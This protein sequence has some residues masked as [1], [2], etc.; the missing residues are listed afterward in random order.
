MKDFIYYLSR[1]YQWLHVHVFGWNWIEDEEKNTPKEGEVCLVILGF[2]KELA[3]FRINPIPYCLN[4]VDFKFHF[5]FIDKGIYQTITGMAWKKTGRFEFV[6]EIK[7][8]PS[9][10]NK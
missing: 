6:S 4:E 3:I 1:K 7:V 9:V 8:D 10:A 5:E 2:K